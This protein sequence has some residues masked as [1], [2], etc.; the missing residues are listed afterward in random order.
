MKPN[1]IT[2][3]PIVAERSL[4]MPR[5]L[6]NLLA[7]AAVTLGGCNLDIANPNA[8]S[9]ES[10]LANKRDASIREVVGVFATY[11]G[12]RAGQINAFGSYGRETYNMT[13]QDGRSVTGPYRDWKQ[14]NAFTAGSEW[15]RYGNYRNAY[16]AMKLIN[17]TPDAIT[18][19]AEKRGGLGVLKTFIALEML[20]IIE[21]RGAIGAV[22]DMTDDVNAALPIVSQDS[23]YKWISTMLDSAKADLDVGTFFFPVN[24]GFSAFGVTANTPAG[25]GQFNRAIKARV[26]AKRGSLGC[27]VPCYT[28]ALTELGGTWIADLTAA[29]RDNGVYAIYSTTSG[30]ALNATSFA[31]NSNLYVHPLIDSIA[32][33]ALDDR[34]RRKVDAKEPTASNDDACSGTYNTRT[35]VDVTAARRPCTYATN[36]TAIP[37]IRNEELVLIRAEARWFTANAAGALTDLAAVRTES[38]ATR[39]GTAVVKFAAPTTDT[40]F[41]DE[42]LLQRTLSLFQEG[43]RFPD[44]RRFGRLAQLGALPQDVAAGFTV[45][46]YS[47]LPAQECDSRAL[48]GNPGGIP[49]SCPGNTPP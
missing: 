13:P 7:A 22:V 14:N 44:Y 27:G 15:G 23:V 47:V 6:T 28:T 18:P 5:T 39:G 11:R 45:A 48:A 43:H 36:V 2:T 42:L 20:H 40:E 29:N 30:D 8:P 24:T 19:P 41:V 3:Q 46:P 4:T 9:R 35:L 26:E 34:Y 37:I 17:L 33:A 32:G 1:T 10:A 49:L 16:E 12:A 38:G 25:F 31:Q 21:A